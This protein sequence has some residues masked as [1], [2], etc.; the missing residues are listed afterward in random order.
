MTRETIEYRAGAPGRSFRHYCLIY[1]VF[2]AACGSSLLFLMTVVVPGLEKSLTRV[3][4]TPSPVLALVFQYA[5]LMTR[6]FWILVL[7]AMIPLPFLLASLTI[8]VG[9]K[10]RRLMEALIFMGCALGVAAV[11]VLLV[12]GIMTTR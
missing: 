6:G 5:A 12:T 11:V 9:G 8:A 10:Q 4:I 7:A 2:I 1:A 3:K